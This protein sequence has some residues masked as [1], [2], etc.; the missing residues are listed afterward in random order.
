MLMLPTT[1]KSKYSTFG[2]GEKQGLKCIMGKE[3]PPPTTYTMK[4]NFDEKLNGYSFGIPYSY[5]K[6]VHIEGLNTQA[7]DIPGPGTYD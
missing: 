3:S 1:L 7:E 2:Y 4:S 6:K 5:Y